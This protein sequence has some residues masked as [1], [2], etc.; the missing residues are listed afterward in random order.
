MATTAWNYWH[1]QK[2]SQSRSIRSAITSTPIHTSG[3]LIDLYDMQL[4][5]SHSEA[6][7]GEVG[8]D[9]CR[10]YIAT[11]LLAVAGA[12]KTTLLLLWGQPKKRTEAIA[13]Q[14]SISDMEGERDTKFAFFSFIYKQR[15]KFQIG[16][17]GGELREFTYL[18]HTI[19]RNTHVHSFAHTIKSSMVVGYVIVSLQRFSQSPNPYN[20]H[21]WIV[22]H[23]LWIRLQI[24]VGFRRRQLVNVGHEDSV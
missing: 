10:P 5:V 3:L 15:H 24:Y 13:S 11:G 9:S 8:F 18:S 21:K 19:L 20:H 12:R 6:P 4:S 14:S 7:S 17:A 1:P 22:G 16:T 2:Q 23:A